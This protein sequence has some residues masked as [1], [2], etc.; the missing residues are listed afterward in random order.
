MQ[1]DYA[2][3]QRGLKA[4]VAAGVVEIESHGWTHM[5][6]DLESPPGP[7]WTADLAGEGSADGW[8]T[9]FE[10]HRRGMESPA[11][12]QLFHMKRSLEDLQ[13][14]FGQRALELRP[15]GSGWSKSQFNHTGRIAAQAGFGLFHAEP[16]FYYYLDKDRVLDMSGIA[17][18]VG[19]TSYDR[20]A[21]L[22]PERWPLHPDG[23]AMLLFHDRDIALQPD[24]V[25]RLFAALPPAYQTLSLNEYIGILHA[26]IDSSGADSWQLT[27]SFDPYYCPYFE[28]HPSSWHLW[29][30]ESFGGRLN[31]L[32]E[33]QI[34]VDNRTPLKINAADFLRGTMTIDLPAGLGTHVWKVEGAKRK[35]SG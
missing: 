31:S 30:S 29:L 9:E 12:V 19:T 18:Q 22:H 32:Q 23:P 10:D 14:D 8:Y 5:Q 34:S 35:G 11:I 7:W 28:T 13:E 25:E 1:Q 20:L 26:Q 6:P 21:D 15:G 3:T 16:D 27:F 4:A 33:V 24:F 17:P 2:S